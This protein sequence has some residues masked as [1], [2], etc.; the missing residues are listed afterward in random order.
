MALERPQCLT[1]ARSDWDIVWQEEE[2]KGIHDFS[3]FL[4]KKPQR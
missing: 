3:I 2:L 4:A 1:M